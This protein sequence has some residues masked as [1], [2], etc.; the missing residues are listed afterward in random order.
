MS[1]AARPAT[2]LAI[3][4]CR[5]TPSSALG[6]ITF[7]QP[8]TDAS[9]LTINTGLLP[10]GNEMQR[11]N[12]CFATNGPVHHQQ[13]GLIRYAC[14]TE[15]MLGVLEL[16]EADYA[17]I[18]ATAETAYRLLQDFNSRSDY[19]HVLRIWNYLDA[20][21]VG[22]GDEERYKLFCVGRARGFGPTVEHYP[23]ACAIG[24]KQ[25]N[26]IL[27]VYWL[28]ARNPGLPLEN[29]RQI[30]AYRYPRAYGPS[31]PGFARATLTT[32]SLLLIS[33]TASIVGHAS[34]HDDDLDAQLNETLNNI[35]TLLQLARTHAPRLNAQLDH[36]SLLKIYV[37]HAEHA[38]H[39]ERSVRQRCGAAPQLLMLAAD[40]C[41]CELLV[42]MDC[43]HGLPIGA[44]ALG[45]PG[46]SASTD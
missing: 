32:A 16:R 36:S 20:I 29:P 19:P 45:F 2:A 41:R 10:L 4:Y 22:D 1:D 27:Q 15:H 28:A 5:D 14:D 30:S 21:N 7:A 39:I 18:A 34:M 37:R 43:I 40:I 13:D 12:E 26:G 6:L 46:L 8:H 31:P 38:A 24:R 3:R 11:Q 33:G 42:E 35:E 9:S 23:A 44:D 25:S 17:G